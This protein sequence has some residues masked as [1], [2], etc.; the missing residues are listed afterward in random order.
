MD[1]D[2]IEMLVAAGWID[3]DELTIHDQYNDFLMDGGELT[4]QQWVNL[5]AE[6]ERKAKEFREFEAGFPFGGVWDNLTPE[7]EAV[8]DLLLEWDLI[9]RH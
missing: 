2:Y 4:F 6:Y 5:S 1:N 3:E 7:M 8:L 9:L